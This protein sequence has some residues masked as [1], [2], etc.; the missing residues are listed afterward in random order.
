MMHRQHFS[1]FF[2]FVI[3]TFRRDLITLWDVERL[4]KEPA[5]ETMV[6]FFFPLSGGLKR[7][8]VDVV[9]VVQTLGDAV[10]LYRKALSAAY[11]TAAFMSSDKEKECLL[12]D[13][14]GRDPRW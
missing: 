4:M 1:E 13:L 8:K 7:P 3:G 11:V 2:S 5:M 12:E 6:R 9:G 14:E 10:E